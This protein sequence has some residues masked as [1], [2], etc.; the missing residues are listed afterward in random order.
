MLSNSDQLFGSFEDVI[1][2][3][4]ETCGETLENI[5][6][7]IH[8]IGSCFSVGLEKS[9][10]QKYLSSLVFWSYVESIRISGQILYLT[11]CGL[12][13]NAFDDIRHLLESIVQ[14]SYIE[15]NHSSCDLNTKLEILKEIEDK[16]EY[17]AP[18]IN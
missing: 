1:K 8:D 12:Y 3:S 18:K 5:R 2:K 15:T 6:N 7:L 17:H 9:P 11:G 10:R 16:K 14:V 4:R 13:R